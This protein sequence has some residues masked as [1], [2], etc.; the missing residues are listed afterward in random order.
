MPDPVTGIANDAASFLLY[1]SACDGDAGS[2]QR[3]LVENR[4]T[5]HGLRFTKFFG[6]WAE[7][8]QS[9]LKKVMVTRQRGERPLKPAPEDTSP[10]LDWLDPA[11]APH[12]TTMRS[13]GRPVTL[14]IGC[15]P[16]LK[17]AAER[18][19]ALSTRTVDVT[20]VSRLLTGL[21]LPH[22]TENGFLFHPTLGVPYLRGTALKAIAHAAAEAENADCSLFGSA[23]SGAGTVAFLDGL[24]LDRITLTAEQIT[25]HY[26]GYYQRG[27]PALGMKREDDMA[28]PADWHEPNPITT[29][30][31][32]IGAVFRIGVRARNADDAEKALQ[33]LEQGLAVFGYGARTTIGHGQ[34]LS[35]EVLDRE[36]AAAEAKRAEARAADERARIALIPQQPVPGKRLM[37]KG[38]AY[39][40]VTVPPR[41]PMKLRDLDNPAVTIMV[42]WDPAAMRIVT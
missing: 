15:T 8:G 24:P 23:E 10:L 28:Q 32:E 5:D 16:L 34:L 27:N 4:C 12:D 2:W 20:L 7:S 6:R 11:N 29:L 13:K 31:V 19:K 14:E 38:K 22:P 21:G 1:A 36:T 30:A 17:E 39:N 25:N 33:W 9:L 37:L 42:D 41:G 40:I 3:E 18:L 35:K 26:S